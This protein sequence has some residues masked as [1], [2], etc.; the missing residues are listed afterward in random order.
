MVCRM[1]LQHA[2]MRTLA[3]ADAT[4]PDRLP[5]WEDL[6][7]MPYLRCIMKEVWRVSKHL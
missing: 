6:E 5:I 4:V 1:F 3:I 2:D 7:D